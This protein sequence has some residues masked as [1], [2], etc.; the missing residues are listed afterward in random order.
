M[1]KEIS[2]K[3]FI[4]KFTAIPTKFIDDHLHFYDNCVKNKFGI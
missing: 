4:K 3:K 2:L 1:E